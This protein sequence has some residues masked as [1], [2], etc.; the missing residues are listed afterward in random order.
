MEKTRLNKLSD[1]FNFCQQELSQGYQ[2]SMTCYADDRA[3][4]HLMDNELR[5]T[6][7]EQ[8]EGKG[9]LLTFNKL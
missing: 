9:P 4:K 6:K 3:Y 2:T 7:T 8:D 5:K 1:A